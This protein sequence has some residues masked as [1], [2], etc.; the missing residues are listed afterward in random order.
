MVKGTI[1]GSTG[2]GA[3]NAIGEMG[4]GAESGI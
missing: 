1:I 4:K 2:L 3:V